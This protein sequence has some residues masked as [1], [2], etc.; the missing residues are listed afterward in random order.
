MNTPKIIAKSLKY[1]L[2]DGPRYR[3][4]S[5]IDTR[6]TDAFQAE[7]LQSVETR[8]FY[9]AENYFSADEVKTMRAAA[10]AMAKE[11]AGKEDHIAFP[12]FAVNRFRK[13]DRVPELSPF[14]CE[15]FDQ[16]GTRYLGGNGVRYQSMYEEKGALGITSVADVP[17]F[18][19]W[20]KRFKIFL[21]L[22]DVTDAN[23]PFVVYEN[24]YSRTIQRKAKEIEYVIAGRRGAYGY[25]CEHEVRK[26]LETEGIQKRS[27]EAGAGSVI[28]VDTRF[29]HHGTPSVDGHKRH[30]LGSYFDIRN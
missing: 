1:L 26:L 17:H 15:Y 20:K 19:D 29:V 23:C 2:W 21:Y 25:L 7:V 9:L 11:T 6:G 10:E 16:I 5:K 14:F 13:A 18:D 12:E 22:N 24:S 27:I 4:S 3:W 8:G 30:L 28:F